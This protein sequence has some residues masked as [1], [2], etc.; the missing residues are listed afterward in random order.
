MPFYHFMEI[1][2]NNFVA[3]AKLAAILLTHG[4]RSFMNKLKSTSLNTDPCG[5]DTSPAGAR[6]GPQ[7]IGLTL[8]FM[9]GKW[10]QTPPSTSADTVSRGWPI[11]LHCRQSIP[12]P[13][14]HDHCAGIQLA[15]DN[16]LLPPP[17]GRAPGNIS[18]GSSQVLHSVLYSIAICQQLLLP[19]LKA[20]LLEGP[21]VR[22]GRSMSIQGGSSESGYQGA[23]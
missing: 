17:Y 14:K 8:L 10:P 15:N 4:S 23:H 16:G 5:F 3:F 9:L 18:S 1:C 2:L 6:S 19:P 13:D 12:P 7:A 21:W 22:R 11:R 20:G